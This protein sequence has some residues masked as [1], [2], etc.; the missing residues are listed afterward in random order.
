MMDIFGNKRIQ[1]L[2]N[3]VRDARGD[4]GDEAYMVL[5]LR[6]QVELAYG[7]LWIVGCDRSTPNGN[8]LYFARKALYEKLDKDGQ[9]RGITAA[10]DLLEKNPPQKYGTDH[11]SNPK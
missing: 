8:A 9:A 4:E 10:R 1:E 2:E 7:L 5:E 6:K 3:E 11:F